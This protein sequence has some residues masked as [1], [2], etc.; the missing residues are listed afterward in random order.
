MKEFAQE[1]LAVVG[2]T[3]AAAL[4][5]LFGAMAGLAFAKGVTP[6]QAIV[7]VLAGVGTGSFGSAGI[8]AYWQLS[9]AT[10]G[11]VAFILAV[12]AMPL[13]GLAFGIVSRWR[14]KAD[15]LADRIADK[16]LGTDP[17]KPRHPEAP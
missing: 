3:L 7:I 8:V 12:L 16:G 2:V 10:A 4:A 5:S 1:F 17:E 9:P 13:L 11:A 6:R 14:G 15:N